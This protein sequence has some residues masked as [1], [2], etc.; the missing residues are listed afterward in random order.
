MARA[1]QQDPP[2]SCGADIKFYPACGVLRPAPSRSSRSRP[3]YAEAR[4]H[5]LEHYIVSIG[6][7]AEM[8][9]GGAIA[10]H[11][12]WHLGLRSSSR[13]RC[14]RASSSRREFDLGAEA[15]IAQIG[16][17]DRQHHE[18]PRAVRDQ[19]R[20]Q[21][22]RRARGERQNPAGRPPRGRSQNMIYVADGP[23]DIPSPVVK[24]RRRQGPT[25]CTTST[26]PTSSNR[27]TACGR[28]VA[29]TITGKADYTRRAA[30]L[31]TGFQ[32]ADPDH[33]RAHRHGS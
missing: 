22:E 7:H 2:A 14:S 19:Q 31:L 10:P 25:A 13:T 1:E 21:Q 16:M 11:V 6:L 29:S 3:E 24:E 32:A 33:R 30:R 20:N 4:D 26:G 23:S 12:D 18:D 8:V 5:S 9:R 15:E 17:D 28:P 27:T